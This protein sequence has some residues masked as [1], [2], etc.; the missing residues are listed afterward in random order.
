M[1]KLILSS[2]LSLLTCL[3][4]L[5]CKENSDE[6]KKSEDA[7]EGA[8]QTDNG[9]LEDSKDLTSEVPS[10]GNSA[11]QD[12]VNSYETYLDQY[13]KAVETKDIGALSDLG[14]KGQELAIK[15]QEIS[16]NMSVEDAQ[17][18]THYMTEKAKMIQ[19]LTLKMSE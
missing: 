1:K 19:E 18:F 15:A 3:I 7:I 14:P 12:Y 16:G 17:K 4:V 8:E 9:I 13:A 2:I 6:S 5:S 11:V 10:F